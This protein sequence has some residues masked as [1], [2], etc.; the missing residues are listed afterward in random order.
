[1]IYT[2]QTKTA[3]KIVFDAHKAG[4]DKGKMSYI[5]HPIHLAEQMETE[6]QI[7]AALLHD[8]VEDSN[9]TLNRLR[10]RGISEEV[11][12][13]VRLLTHNK[14]EP[15]ADYIATIKHSLNTDA[16]KIK[17]ADLEHN[18]DL[19]RYRW[20]DGEEMKA[21]KKYLAA[22]KSLHEWD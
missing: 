19:S 17:I 1:M 9:W 21:S 13:I 12:D 11:I 16:I 10:F 2:P 8:V 18:M 6:T 4:F 3:M 20:D 22:Y 5:Y 7:C 15:Y 14:G